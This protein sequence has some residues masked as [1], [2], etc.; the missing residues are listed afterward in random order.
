MRIVLGDRNGA[1]QQVFRLRL[2][3]LCAF[4]DKGSIGSQGAMHFE[5][6]AD[7]QLIGGRE[8]CTRCAQ[9]RR[10]RCQARGRQVR[11]RTQATAVQGQPGRSRHRIPSSMSSG[12]SVYQRG[13]NR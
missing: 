6:L 9:R 7:L 13:R 10:Q 11:Q 5:P 4:A 1:N 3:Q 12:A 2:L 8:K